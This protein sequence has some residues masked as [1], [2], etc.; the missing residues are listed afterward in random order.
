MGSMSAFGGKASL[1]P[2]L[3]SCLLLTLADIVHSDRRPLE[4]FRRG[5]IVNSPTLS[6]A[7]SL[8]YCYWLL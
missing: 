2:H 8:D 7:R 3:R 1:I 6:G 4:Q 5:D